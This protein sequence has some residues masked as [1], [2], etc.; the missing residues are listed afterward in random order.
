MKYNKS[1]QTRA[2]HEQEEN[3]EERERKVVTR[4]IVAAE[5]IPD[6]SKQIS[7]DRVEDGHA[8]LYTKILDRSR[9]SDG[10]RNRAT[11]KSLSAS[12]F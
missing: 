8:L 9:R 3:D 4:M 5:I 2:L 12:W 11:G 6:K 10:G 1:S 7:T